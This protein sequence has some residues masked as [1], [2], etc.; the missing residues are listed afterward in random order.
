LTAATW[1]QELASC[2]RQCDSILS[3][4]EG[5]DMD[6]AS[7]A[8]L[9]KIASKIKSALRTAWKENTTDMFDLG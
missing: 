9:L 2:L 1:A 6:D 3:K 4:A 5:E 7:D 8:D